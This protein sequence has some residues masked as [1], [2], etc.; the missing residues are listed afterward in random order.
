MTDKIKVKKFAVVSFQTDNSVEAVPSGWLAEDQKSCCWP[1]EKPANFL[2]LIRDPC[3]S[4]QIDWNF[5]EVEVVKFYGKYYLIYC[6][7]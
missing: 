5:W 3:S 7:Q 2:N 6:D 1:D 4:P